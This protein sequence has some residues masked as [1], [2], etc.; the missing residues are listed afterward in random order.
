MRA[1]AFRLRAHDDNT[2]AGNG[3]LPSAFGGALEA[4]RTESA[5]GA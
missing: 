1:G 5:L 3:D 2:D 4:A